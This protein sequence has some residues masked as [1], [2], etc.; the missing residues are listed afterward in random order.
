MPLSSGCS[1]GENKLH[2][3]PPAVPKD[4]LTVVPAAPPAAPFAGD[5]AVIVGGDVSAVPVVSPPVP[6]PGEPDWMTSIAEITGSSAAP[7]S[8]RTSMMPSVTVTF[9]IVLT[10]AAFGP[11]TAHTSRL[12]T[13]GFAGVSAMSMLKTRW[14]AHGL[15][16]NVSAARKR[17]S[18]VPFAI[19]IA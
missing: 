1:N 6:L 18:Y 10:Y 2:G 14:P 12:L 4:Q 19:G 13:S 3:Q 17:T 11:T 16:K 9:V 15:A 8:M 5:C 7:R